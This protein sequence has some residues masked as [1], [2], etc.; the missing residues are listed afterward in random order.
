MSNHL[1]IATIT[2]A[3]GE[4][5]Q[6]ALTKDVAGATVHVGRPEVSLGENGQSVVALFLYQV[7]PN[8]AIRNA[9]LP[10]RGAGPALI[11][12]PIV[13]LKLHYLLSFYGDAAT[14]EPERML[15]AIVR[16]LEERPLLRRPVIEKVIADNAE[17]TGSDLLEDATIRAQPASLNLDELSKLWS[18][19]FQVPYVLSVAYECSTVVVE[20]D[21]TER[22]PLPATRPAIAPYPVGG[23]RIDSIESL[24]GR[25]FPLTWGGTARLTGQMLNAPGLGLRV[26][27]ADV[28]MTETVFRDGA[29]E[30]PLTDAAFG[31][32]E[33]AAGVHTVQ[34]TLPPPPGVPPHLERTSD[35]VPLLLRSL[36]TLPD[37][38]VTITSPPAA[39]RDGTLDVTFSPAVIDGQDVRLL[40]DQRVTASPASY[41]LAAQV[42]A[43]FPASTLTFPFAGVVDG[44]YLMRAQVDGLQSA[45]SLGNDPS[46]SDYRHIVGPEVVIP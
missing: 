36:L 39:P 33:L 21:V 35:R 27:G 26:G 18:V 28:V 42:P 11:A 40:L 1:A 44:T 20:A 31:G 17:L 23:P 14:F 6:E 46:A 43:V 24:V 10:Y 32:V 29:I 13:P 19:M 37:S 8:G 12:K 2:A 9:H 15:G 34:T 4:T 16:V 45:V 3:L 38:A 25:G 30:L 22:Q 7:S 41:V 5:I